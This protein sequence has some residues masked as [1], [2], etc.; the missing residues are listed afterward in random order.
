MEGVWEEEMEVGGVD[1]AGD[2][3]ELLEKIDV[4]GEVD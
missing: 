2:L 3:A 1:R 4:E